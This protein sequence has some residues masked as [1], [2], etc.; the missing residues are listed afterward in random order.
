MT[1]NSVPMLLVYRFATGLGLGTAVPCAVSLASE[2]VPARRRATT[3]GLLF[4]GFPFG[5][6]L[7]GLLGSRVLPT[8]GWHGLFDGIGSCRAS[9]RRQ[10][11]RIS[12][13]AAILSTCS[14][15]LRMIIRYTL[16][17]LS[18]H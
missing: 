17:P 4:A 3:A 15:V 2:F 16:A 7:A 14:G 6:V 8:A 9:I 10:R 13:E 11:T 5:G 1:A 12:P 18:R